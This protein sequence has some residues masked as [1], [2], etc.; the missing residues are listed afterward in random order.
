MHSSLTGENTLC[1][2]YTQ[3]LLDHIESWSEEAD[4]QYGDQRVRNFPEE[5]SSEEKMRDS[6]FLRA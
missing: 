6:K 1:T 5:L 2:A 4:I 3:Y